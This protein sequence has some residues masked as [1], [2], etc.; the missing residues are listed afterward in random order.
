MLKE[1]Q[2]SEHGSKSVS[3][4]SGGTKRKLC[5]AISLLVDSQLTLLDEPSSGLDPVS[6]RFLWECIARAFRI[7][8]YYN[9]SKTTTTLKTTTTTSATIPSGDHVAGRQ[10]VAAERPGLDANASPQSGRRRAAILTTHSM[11]EAEALCTRIGIVVR[12]RMRCL[13]SAQHLKEKYGSAF[14]LHIKLKEASVGVEGKVGGDGTSEINAEA[15]NSVIKTKSNETP[16]ESD[17]EPSDLKLSPTESN[18]ETIGDYNLGPCPMDSDLGQ[19]TVNSSEERLHSYISQLFGGSRIER[20]EDVNETSPAG[21]AGDSSGSAAASAAS[22]TVQSAPA[23]SPT[24][25]PGES[26]TS[27][28]P[29]LSSTPEVSKSTAAVPPNPAISLKE[30]FG[31]RFVYKIEKKVVPSLGVVFAALEK[32]KSE[33]DVEEY[34]FSQPTLE[35]VFLDFARSQETM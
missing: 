29:A 35:Q 16:R 11:E 6:K 28:A 33:V 13:G 30:C 19:S 34:S 25:A 5:F 31:G 4:I 32:A 17:H 26:L 7:G 27:V 10:R 2:I 23:A 12:G 3:A 18:L 1:L 22:L 21:S 14:L 24:A 9:M 15:S 8:D 20:L